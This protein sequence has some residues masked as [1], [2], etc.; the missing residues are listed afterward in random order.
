MQNKRQFQREMAVKSALL[1]SECESGLTCRKNSTFLFSVAWA[2]VIQALLN[3]GKQN[4]ASVP[5]LATNASCHCCEIGLG[6]VLARFADSVEKPYVPRVWYN[7][8]YF[9]AIE[10]DTNQFGM[11]EVF[12]A[13]QERKCPVKVTA[14][15]TDAVTGVIECDDRSDND[16]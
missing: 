5:E 11:K 10:C 7:F 12:S 6:N 8:F 3:D 13:L 2:D 4:F 16:V 14:T 15:H 1:N 9:L